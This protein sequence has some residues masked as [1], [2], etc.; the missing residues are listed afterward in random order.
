LAIDAQARPL[1]EVRAA[2]ESVTSAANGDIATDLL[3][4]ALHDIAVP[5]LT[6]LRSGVYDGHLNTSSAT[7]LVSLLMYA[8]GM[9]PTE[10]YEAEMGRAGTPSAIITDLTAALGTAID[11]LTRPID[12]IKH[13]AKT[14][15]VGI[16][17]NE[18][19]LLHAPL[20]AETLAAGTSLD[21]LGYR[22]LRTLAA[23]SV[24][25][26]QVVGYTRYRIE[27]P[28]EA[29]GLQ[30]A[31][32]LVTGRGGIAANM[33]SRTATDSALRGTKHRVAERREVTAFRGLRDGR[34]GIMIPEVKD[35]QTVGITLLHINFVPYLAAPE[36]K[37]VLQAYQGRYN[38]LVDA[39]TETQPG[40]DDQTLSRVP[41]IELLTEPVAVLAQ[42]WASHT[43]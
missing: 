38:A 6:G 25:A 33:T 27:V 32:V 2:L 17:R 39:V 21:S 24:T 10:S 29:N 22:T 42:H 12:A 23:L 3:A 8:T 36:A 15:T 11:E 13:Q 9:L 41:T 37:A 31:T 26:Q 7:R 14:V 16:S 19:T 1:R 20:V 43:Q 18:D 40:F 30:S 5:V 28:P 34:T 4:A 35:T